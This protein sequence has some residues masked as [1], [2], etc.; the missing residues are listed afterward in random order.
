LRGL[1]AFKALPRNDPFLES[2]SGTFLA[3]PVQVEKYLFDEGT[4]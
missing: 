4:R 3:V 2:I 1:A